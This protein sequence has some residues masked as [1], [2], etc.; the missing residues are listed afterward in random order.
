MALLPRCG[1]T[2][3]FKLRGYQPELHAAVFPHITPDLAFTRYRTEETDHVEEAL[4]GHRNRAGL[5]G[6]MRQPWRQRVLGKVE[7]REDR[8]TYRRDRAERGQLHLVRDSAE[9]NQRKN[10]D[11]EYSCQFQVWNASGADRLRSVDPCRWQVHRPSDQLAGR[12]H[13][14]QLSC[15][16]SSIMPTWTVP[17]SKLFNHVLPTLMRQR[18]G[19]KL[20][21]R[22]AS[23]RI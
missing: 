22:E 15:V 5:I 17:V 10:G 2:V 4:A 20:V 19:L 16:L 6:R 18:K 12:V 7:E 21:V 23:Q 3:V 14:R 1:R 8:K 9:L 11:V 13:A